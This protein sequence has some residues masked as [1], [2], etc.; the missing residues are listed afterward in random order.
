VIKKLT[1]FNCTLGEGPVWD[2]ESCKLWWVD[3]KRKKIFSLSKDK[4]IDF[5]NCSGQV[6]CLGLLNK[7]HLI[8]AEET[9][10]FKLCLDDKTFSRLG[11]IAPE[12]GTLRYNDGKIGPDGRFWFGSLDDTNFPETGCLYS[13]DCN[14][15]ANKHL[16]NIRCSNGIGWT[17]DGN[18]MFYTDSM[19]KVIWSF[20]FDKKNGIISNK[21]VFAEITADQVPDGLAVDLDGNV[22]SAMWDGWCVVKFDASGYEVNRILLPVP[23]PTSC[24][25]GEQDMK[26]LFITSARID[27]D[28]R[29]L[30]DAPDSGALFSIE[31]DTPGVPVGNF[32]S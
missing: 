17:S 9:G 16:E 21:T 6:G 3:I 30:S 29:I 26:T 8:V 25:F 12:K 4:S 2:H 13:I 10:I 18:R 15:I 11:E 7:N 20:D 19:R 28:K 32:K 14:G 27:L 1:N 5:I 22:W 23:R 31:V 24:A